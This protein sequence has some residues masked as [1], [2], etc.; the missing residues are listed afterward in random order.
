MMT[1]ATK[2]S[3]AVDGKSSETDDTRICGTVPTLH[4]NTSVERA[5]ADLSQ[6]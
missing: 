6:G 3:E 4:H 1:I 5:T 2:H